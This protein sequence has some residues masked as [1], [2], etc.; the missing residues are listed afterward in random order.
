MGQRLFTILSPGKILE[1]KTRVQKHKTTK[2][3]EGRVASENMEGKNFLKNRVDVKVDLIFF[4][5]DVES[6]NLSSRV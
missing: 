3:I 5:Y 1:I 2:C 6:E 4:F